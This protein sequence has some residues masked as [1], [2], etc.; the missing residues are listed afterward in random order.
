MTG[1]LGSCLALSRV[2]SISDR[3]YKME[4]VVFI[5]FPNE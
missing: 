5:G 3:R 2:M 1:A 4:D